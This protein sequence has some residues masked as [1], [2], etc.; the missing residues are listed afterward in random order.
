MASGSGFSHIPQNVECINTNYRTINT[1]IPVPESIELIQQLYKYES[2]S[3]HGQYPMIWDRA[4]DISVYDPYGNKWLDF[5]STIFVANAGHSNKNILNALQKM[6]NK[7]LL[8]SYTYPNLERIEYLKKLIGVTPDYLNKAYMVSS[9]TETTEMALKLIRMANKDEKRSVV[10][11]FEGAYHGR[12]L[13]AQQLTGNA[14]AKEWV[15]N[16]DPD[17]IH[18]G[19]P[20]PWIEEAKNESYFERE[21]DKFCEKYNLD[22]EKDISGFIIE[23]FQGWGAFFYPQEYIKALSNY[24]KK[25]RI[26][27]CF[28]EM[29][30]GF[31]RTGKLFGFQHYDIEPDLVCLGKGASSG[32]PLSLL[33]GKKELMDIPDIGSMSSTHSANPLACAVGKANLEA[34][35]EE[36]LIENACKLGEHFHKRL[37]ELSQKFN[38]YVLNSYGLGLLGAIV[39]KST[40]HSVFCDKICEIS[41]QKGLLLVHTGRESIKLAPP[42]SITKEALDEGLDVLEEVFTDV[43]G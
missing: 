11:T 12:T 22:P 4:E 30:A 40:E 21:M 8:H 39:F 10:I 43:I 23:T 32:F 6:V 36:G 26:I 5:T 31:G 2:R 1:K 24:C 34:L 33:L 3:V 27:I 35:C 38:K 28:D 7:P 20:Y 9:G 16:Q 14:S 41:F 18:L 19:F 25:N 17:I 42:L 15:R 13:G 37:R 29:Q